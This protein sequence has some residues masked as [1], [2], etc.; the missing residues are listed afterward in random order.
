MRAKDLSSWLKDIPSNAD[1]VLVI[2][3]KIIEFDLRDL[4]VR[5]GK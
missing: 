3:G 4:G 2:N 1:I 5:S